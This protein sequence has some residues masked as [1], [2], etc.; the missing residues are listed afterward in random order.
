MNIEIIAGSPRKPSLSLR[1]AKHLYACLQNREG[2]SVGLI[3]MQDTVF[4]FIQN[5]WK[6]ADEAPEE[7]RAIAKRMFASDALI[8][9]SPEY[10][11]GYSPAL[12][13]FLDHFPKQTRKAV[14]IATSSDGIMGGMR[15]AQ[16][17]L[18]MTPAFFA[19]PSPHLL[20][21]PQADKKFGENGELI[22]GSFQLKIDNFVT[23]FLWLANKL[24][25]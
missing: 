11:G 12:K 22:D 19:I 2:L 13:N 3:N 20:I 4:P 16:Q 7:H 17:L 1:V 9:V 21:V 14:G 15:S 10:N 8:L 5:V 25:S 18:L 24:K 6:N 23:E